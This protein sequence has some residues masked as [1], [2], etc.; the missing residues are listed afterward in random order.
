MQSLEVVL[1]VL[2]DLF[3]P[4]LLVNCVAV[5]SVAINIYHYRLWSKVVTSKPF[6]FFYT[7]GSKK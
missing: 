3:L 7:N 4:A 6:F 5:S 1:V 2:E